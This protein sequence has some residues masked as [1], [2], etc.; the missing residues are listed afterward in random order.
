[1]LS[2][3]PLTARLKGRRRA[4]RRTVPAI[5]RRLFLGFALATLAGACGFAP[6]YGPGGAAEGLRGSLLV[7]APDDRNAFVLVRHLERRLG[8][9]QNAPYLLSYK[10]ATTRQGVGITP[11]QETTRFNVLGRIEYTVTD[12]AT[13]AVLSEGAVENFTGYSATGS[14]VA[15]IEATRDAEER[16]MI[17]LADQIVSRLIATA[18][19]WRK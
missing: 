9:P 18:P 6:V 8:Q 4:M 13:M 19:V 3:D 17:I 10:I 11:A 1:M 15:T 5:R 16:L 7:A 12:R 14:I 2:F